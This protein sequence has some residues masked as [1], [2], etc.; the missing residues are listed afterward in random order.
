MKTGCAPT[1]TLLALTFLLAPCV[2]S[3]AGAKAATSDRTITQVVTL[4]ESLMEESKQDGNEEREMYGK[5]KCYCDTNEEAKKTEI[6]SLNEQIELLESQIEELLASTG[7]LSKEVAKLDADMAENQASRATAESIRAEEERV[8]NALKQ[9]LESAMD[10]MTDAIQVLGDIG[11]DQTMEQAAAD[12]KYMMAGFERP[13]SPLATKLQKSVKQALIAASSLVTTKQ[14]RKLESFIQAP[15]T[16]TYTAQSGEVVGILKDMKDTFGANLATATATEE[17]AVTAFTKYMATMLAAYREMDASHTEKQGKLSGNDQDLSIKK[18]Q[19]ADARDALEDAETFLAQLQDMCAAKAKEYKNRVLLRDNEEAALSEA[20]SIL[21]SD[22]A[23]ATFGTV[24]ATKTGATGPTFMQLSSVRRHRQVAP[25][26]EEVQKRKAAQQFLAKAAGSSPRIAKVLALLQAQN[27]FQV[28]LEQVEKML[29]LIDQEAAK[30]LE[31]RDWC[32]D[33]RQKTNDDIRAKS[34]QI[35]LLEG[36]I[37]ELDSTINHPQTGLKVEIAQ[38]E[39][40]LEENLADQKSETATR[41][42]ENTKYQKDVSNLQEAQML[43]DKA[44]KV[45]RKYY[46]SIMPSLVQKSAQQ[47]QQPSPPPTWEDADGTY[48]GQ[49]TGG[50][51]AIDML[52][53]IL[54]ESKKEETVAHD[55]EL[56]GQHAYEDSMATLTTEQARLIKEIADLREALAEAE[57]ELLVKKKDLEA[58][59]KEKAALE[60]YLEK[61]KPGCDFITSNY[62]QRKASQI[63]EKEALGRAKT[64]IKSTPAYLTAVG[65]AHNE[66]LGD[67]KDLCAT[68]TEA[69]VDCKACLASTSVP[70]YCAGHPG[71]LGC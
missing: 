61:I 51:S 70:G 57:E 12:H 20:I 50:T 44:I 18:G 63:S 35:G 43:L 41:K 24:D 36:Q 7:I 9:D 13:G 31:Q 14:A 42:D 60:A 67:C 54:G 65:Q 8:Y 68:V 58:T 53:F 3:A 21:N 16:A 4:L 69:H 32:V 33:E 19:L 52:E 64:L 25:R 34:T 27:P 49:S 30:D 6:A 15:F 2:A 71:T 48:T 10:Q 62:D 26:V 66:T 11:A 38:D 55:A 29:G 45:L 1:T 59:L 47:Q 23:F 17:K 28:V 40:M 46:S 56:A 5:Y 39:S 22:A 37:N